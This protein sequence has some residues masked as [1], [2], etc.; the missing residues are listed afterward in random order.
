MSDLSYEQWTERLGRF[1]FDSAHD[2]EEILFAVDDAALAEASGFE[3]TE[4]VASLALAVRSVIGSAWAVERVSSRVRRWKH[5]RGGD[6]PAIP[7]L[8][9]TVLA[10]F[11]MG[12]HARFA[13][14]N[15]YVP[16][17]RLIDHDDRDEGPPGSF[18]DHI[19]WLWRDLSAWAN[20]E[21]NGRRGSI[22]VRDPGH[23]RYVGLAVQHALFKMADLRHLDA[24]FRRIGLDP[25]DEVPAAQLRRA[26]AVWTADRPEPWAQRLHRLSTDPDLAAH[27]EIVLEREAR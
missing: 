11:R 8:A 26:L 10:A 2:G 14:H 15:Y 5:D 12:E 1:F 18:T 27:C 19:E 23:H 6:H 16:L 13:A 4:A 22:E 25:G 24:F 3:E 21:L 7:F 17:R 20:V 9:L